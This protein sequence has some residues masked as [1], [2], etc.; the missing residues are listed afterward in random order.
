MTSGDLVSNHALVK[1]HLE[2]SCP[3]ILK[4]DNISYHRYHKIN[5]QRFCKD[6]TNTHSVLSPA[7]M[8]ADLQV[9]YI[10]D[11]G[12]MLNRHA[13]LIFRRAGKYQLDG[14]LMHIV[15]PNPSR[16]KLSAGDQK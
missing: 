11:L 15:R 16:I 1:C 9:Q 5:M 10:R 6:L 13:Q 7:S 4:V 12:G 2:F 14:C 8:A 3:A